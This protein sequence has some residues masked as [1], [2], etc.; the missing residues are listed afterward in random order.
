MGRVHT[1]TVPTIAQK[2]ISSAYIAV[3]QT[4]HYW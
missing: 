2:V 1:H 4:T 3:L